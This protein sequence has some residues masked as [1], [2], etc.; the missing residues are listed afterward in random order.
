MDP[1]WVQTDMGDVGAKLLGVEK[2]PTTLEES[3]D[4]MM[5][6][7]GEMSREK[8]GGMFAHFSGKISDWH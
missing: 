8:H 1:G 6:V 4:G 3:C 7:F 2:A 5:K